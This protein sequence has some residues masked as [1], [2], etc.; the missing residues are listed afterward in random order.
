MVAMMSAMAMMVEKVHQQTDEK[1]QIRKSTHQVGPVFA[2]QEVSRHSKTTDQ[3]PLSAARM[4][5][6]VTAVIV[7]M[8][9]HLSLPTQVTS[10]RIARPAVAV[11]TVSL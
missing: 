9:M 7:I 10:Y 5:G 8:S 6:L 2:P 4:P 3:Q 11:L 1:E